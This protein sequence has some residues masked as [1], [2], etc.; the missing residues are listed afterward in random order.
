M[1]RYWTGGQKA[2]SEREV[3]RDIHDSI[4]IR[5]VSMVLGVEGILSWW[6]VSIDLGS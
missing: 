6:I 4:E 5:H 2:S 3:S 1:S